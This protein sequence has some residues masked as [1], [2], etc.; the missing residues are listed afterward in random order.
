MIDQTLAAPLVGGP[1]CVQVFA[2]GSAGSRGIGSHDQRSAP[3]RA[4]N[5]RTTP[6]GSSTC[7]LSPIAEP[8]TTR[9]SI[10]AGGE[11]SSYSPRYLSLSILATPALRSICPWLP[12]SGQVLPSAASSAIRR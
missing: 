12:K 1:P 9:S 2:A 5:A 3:D 10:I 4:S 11:V 7:P 8:T 6:D